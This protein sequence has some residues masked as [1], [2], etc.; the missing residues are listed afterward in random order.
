MVDLC[1]PSVV[2]IPVWLGTDMDVGGVIDRAAEA[3]TAAD[4]EL[5]IGLVS[6]IGSGAGEVVQRL[7]AELREHCNYDVE[8]VKLSSYFRSEAPEGEFE[9]QRIQR[10]I[11][12]GNSLCEQNGD[13]AA[14]ARLAIFQIAF[15]RDRLERLNTS[16]KARFAYI[17]DSLKRPA[18]VGLLRAVYGPQF[19]LVGFQAPRPERVEF[20]LKANLSSTDEQEKRKI[21]Q[22]LLL[23][24][25][26]EG[27]QYGQKVNDTFA[28]SDYYLGADEPPAR[29][30]RLLFGDRAIAPEFREFA[31]YVAYAASARSLSAGRKV[32]AVLATEESVI[33]TGFNDVPATEQPD[34]VTGVDAS[35]SY[36]ISLVE[37]TL[38]RIDEMLETM[39]RGG[40]AEARAQAMS[41][42]KG[43]EILSIIEGQ[44]AVHAEAAAIGDAARRGVAIAH[45]D[46]YCT[47]YP[48]H[49]CFKTA[50]DAQI[51][52]VYYIEPY[53]KSRA[54]LMYPGNMDRLIP[55][56]GLAPRLFMPIFKDRPV[57]SADKH[58][59]FDMADARAGRLARVSEN[60]A[61]SV[62]EREGEQMA[63]GLE[64]VGND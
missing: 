42:L 14:V 35:E 57:P 1:E 41:L 7:R 24:D 47:T 15:A 48:C 2:V 16:P 6:P 55:Y 51:R 62:A 45:A 54:E 58:G 56:V 5:V 17:I 52:R 43:S 21:V 44:R 33:A 63:L 10:L 39:H 61:Q 31:M 59:R 46:L 28:Q 23:L 22:R 4:P 26:D 32:G 37:D 12:A 34:I 50:I 13:P 38:Q 20:L 49:L 11:A 64:G 9:D 29:L 8:I 60:Y 40:T 36:K 18:E 25:A 27:A 30:M 19:V 53:P 3:A